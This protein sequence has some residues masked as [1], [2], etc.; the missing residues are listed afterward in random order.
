METQTVIEYE[1]IEPVSNERFFTQNYEEA[2]NHYENGWMVYETHR[3]KS[4]PTLLTQT[5]V[6]V[7][8]RWNHKRQIQEE[9]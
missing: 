7:T 2:S 1:V 4:Q 3:T 8:V 9:R 6:Y 5:R